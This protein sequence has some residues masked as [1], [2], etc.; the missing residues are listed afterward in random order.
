MGFYDLLKNIPGARESGMNWGVGM[1][2]ERRG[3]LTAEA[4]WVA[5][6]RH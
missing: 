5:G 4:G 3:L 1:K 2:Q 6:A